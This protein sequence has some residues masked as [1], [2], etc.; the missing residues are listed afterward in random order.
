MKSLTYKLDGKEVDIENINNLTLLV[1][2]NG[3]GKSFIMKL[4]WLV[5]MVSGTLS[6]EEGQKFSEEDIKHLITL[7]I[8][9]SLFDSDTLDLELLA[10]IN[11]NGEYVNFHYRNDEVVFTDIN[12]TSKD[13]PMP[14]YLSTNTRLF[15]GLANANK[16]NEDFF[17]DSL[18][19]RLEDTIIPFY[20][21]LF[22]NGF[23]SICKD[24]YLEIDEE[25]VKRFKDNYE[26]DIT[27]IKYDSNKNTFLYKDSTGAEKNCN[28]L[29][30]GQQSLVI[31]LL[32]VA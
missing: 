27:A 15:S 21:F 24:E 13:H 10:T 31:M 20:D 18:N 29:S 16:P 26:I 23:S 12:I 3:T 14:R 17:N 11:D 28:R 1:G 5:N 32:G 9:R 22:A 19:I 7:L 6:S 2:K 8:R 4:T 30:N 25:R